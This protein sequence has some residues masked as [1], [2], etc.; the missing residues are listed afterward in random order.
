MT[1]D[2]TISTI[3]QVTPARSLRTRPRSMAALF[4]QLHDMSTAI[5]IE[6]LRQNNHSGLRMYCRY[7]L[8]D[9]ITFQVQAGDYELSRTEEAPSLFE[10]SRR[11]YLFCNDPLRPSPVTHNPGKRQRLFDDFLSEIQASEASLV[12]NLL[13][14]TLPETV[15][16][17]I[18]LQAWPNLH[19]MDGNEWRRQNAK[20]EAEMLL[21]QAIAEENRIARVCAEETAGAMEILEAKRT[22]RAQASQR[23][24]LARKRLAE[25]G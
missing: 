24:E 12:L 23:V 10:A 8:D 15:T 17:D 19:V 25:I 20:R 6:H 18:L 16:V 11:L 9:K 4:S 1:T 2:W 14:K 7:L 3:Q 21:T 22:L 5:K 13:T